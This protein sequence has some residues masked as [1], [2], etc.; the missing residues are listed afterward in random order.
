MKNQRKQKIAVK[1]LRARKDVK[2]GSGGKNPTGGHQP[3][4][5]EKNPNSGGLSPTGLRLN[6]NETLVSA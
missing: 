1:D 4:D 6:H 2:G 5:S 3:A